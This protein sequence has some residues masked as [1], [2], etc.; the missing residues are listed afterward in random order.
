MKN[1][2]N[3]IV[4]GLAIVVAAIVLGYAVTNR[5]HDRVDDYFIQ[6]VFLTKLKQFSLPLRMYVTLFLLLCLQR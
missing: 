3:A 5:N 6:K 4:F 2:L 1:S